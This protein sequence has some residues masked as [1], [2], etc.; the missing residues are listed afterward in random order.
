MVKIA[1]NT[2]GVQI[3]TE[4]PQRVKIVSLS[5]TLHAKIYLNFF[6]VMVLYALGLFH[7]N[8]PPCDCKT[9]IFPGSEGCLVLVQLPVWS[10][11]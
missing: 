3:C 1:E 10:V 4:V 6:C 5:D 2:P 9:E 7:S 8:S 11:I